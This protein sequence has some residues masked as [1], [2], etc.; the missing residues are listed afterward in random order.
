MNITFSELKIGTYFTINEY[1]DYEYFI[2]IEGGRAV[3][4][5]TGGSP[6]IPSDTKVT[7]INDE[8]CIKC[9]LH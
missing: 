5:S 6:I 7:I 3:N 2:K 4:L 1:V 9:T 8:I